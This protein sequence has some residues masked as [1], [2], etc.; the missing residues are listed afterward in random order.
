VVVK[1]LFLNLLFICL[2]ANLSASDKLIDSI[3]KPSIE[4]YFKKHKIIFVY[5]GKTQ[6]RDYFVIIRYNHNQIQ[7]RVIVDKNGAI[8]SISEDLDAMD[9]A[10]EGC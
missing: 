8:L 5:I 7:D 2:S 1:T 4:K 6:K 3:I 10:E 9:A